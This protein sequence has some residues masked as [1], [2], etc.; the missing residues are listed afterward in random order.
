MDSKHS[1]LNARKQQA[2][3]RGV[4]G[5]YRRHSPQRPLLS[6]PRCS[7][8]TATFCSTVFWN[9]RLSLA[10]DRIATCSRKRSSVHL[11]ARYSFRSM[12]TSRKQARSSP[13]PCCSAGRTPTTSKMAFGQGVR[14]KKHRTCREFLRGRTRIFWRRAGCMAR[15]RKLQWGLWTKRSHTAMGTPTLPR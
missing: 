6:P 1:A 4:G 8:P 11:G 3:P 7:H 5:P 14:S 15:V 12:T 13:S 10:S 9:C 2:T